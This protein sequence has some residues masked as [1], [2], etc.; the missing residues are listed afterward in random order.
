MSSLDRPSQHWLEEPSI[1]R[2]RGVPGHP[3]LQDR[4]RRR[5]GDPHQLGDPVLARCYLRQVRGRLLELPCEA[6]SM[7]PPGDLL[8]PHPTAGAPDPPP[9][10]LQPDPKPTEPQPGARFSQAP[11]R[12]LRQRGFR[13]SIRSPAS[14]AT[15]R[16][17]NQVTPSSRRSSVVMLAGFLCLLVFLVSHKKASFVCT[18]KLVELARPA[19]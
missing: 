14:K 7:W 6:A 18:S 15:E 2:G 19:S 9:R 8:G 3:P 10:V 5:P 16:T 4:A 17:S 12:D 11:H 1:L 13:P